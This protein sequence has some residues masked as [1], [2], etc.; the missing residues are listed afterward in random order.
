MLGY[1]SSNSNSF[2]FIYWKL[3]IFGISDN[4]IKMDDDYFLGKKLEK[5]DFFYVK[6]GKVIPLITNANFL[7][8]DHDSVKKNI[9][10]YENLAKIQKEEQNNYNFK[11]SMYL[12]LELIL[13][14]FHASN[15]DITYV[16]YFRHNAL[17]INLIELKEA[18][19]LIYK[20][21]F[22]YNTLDCDYRISGYIQFQFFLLSYTFLKY[23]KQ[24]NHIPSK[25]LSLKNTISEIN[26]YPL[27]CINKGA[28]NYTKLNLY[29]EKIFLEYL[30]PNPSPFEIVDY[31]LVNLSFN[32]IYL[33]NGL[34]MTNQN[35]IIDMITQ[36][37]AF[38]L[39]FI[40]VIIAILL[41]IKVSNKYYYYYN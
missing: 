4:I 29:E 24:V 2:Q 41:I 34:L 7:K 21:K 37:N 40:I 32:T 25:Y 31:K 36:N 16:P 19:D 10:F 6:N 30:F 38:Y 12:T 5:K 15:N 26:K 23:Y 28:E 35:K 9:K 27:F 33:M 1:D 8:I 22:R 18:H 11:F 14:I 17:P 13:N 3:K 20:S 39:F